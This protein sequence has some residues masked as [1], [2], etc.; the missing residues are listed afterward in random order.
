MRSF[1]FSQ[2]AGAIVLLASA[3]AVAS[4][5]GLAPG[6]T[7]APV[8]DSIITSTTAAVTLPAITASG[9]TV[10]GSLPSANVAAKVTETVSATAPSGITA[11]AKHR[12]DSSTPFV[13]LYVEFSS[14]ASVT[15]SALPALT[16]TSSS[17]SSSNT[18][19][20]ALDTSSGW[21]LPLLNSPGTVSGDTVSFASA[22]GTV[23][24]APSQ[25][26]V[27]ALY[28]LAASPSSSP[29]ASPSASPVASPNT[30]LFDE[31]SPA[32][33]TFTVTE[34]GYS[35]TFTEQTNC[36]ASPAPSP[37][38]TSSP[39]VVQVSPSSATPASAGAA[40][41]FTVTPGEETGSCTIT[42]TDGHSATATVSASVA[43]DQVIIYDRKRQH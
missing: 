34:A 21:Q 28:T 39:Y 36:T 17:I 7:P 4:C 15:L 33:Q 6:Y 19:Y 37:V 13:L 18:Y 35:G 32:P 24:I 1:R 27:F 9:Y 38:P 11:L 20:L 42:V 8:N 30:L 16:F 12:E 29:S 43:L 23:S 5:S 26:A 2:L 31:S 40:V 41:T 10:N 3:V 22:S 14:D 25:P